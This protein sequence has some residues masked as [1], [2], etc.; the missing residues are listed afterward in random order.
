MSRN[1]TYRPRTTRENRERLKEVATQLNG[2]EPA[3]F[4]ES[5][6]ILLD[7]L[8]VLNGSVACSHCEE[9]PI[10]S[11]APGRWECWNCQQYTNIYD[12]LGT[13]EPDSTD[14]PIVP[15]Q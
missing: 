13:E 5:L 10:E 12:V 2:T 8:D 9:E 11:I 4:H 15:R 14:I 3:E 6:G 7:Y 1:R